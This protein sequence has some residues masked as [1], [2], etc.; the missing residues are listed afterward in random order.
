MSEKIF[1]I[2]INDA[3]DRHDG[4]PL[5]RLR[6]ELEKS[7][8]EYVM[9]AA[10]MEPD[11]RA[12]T[13]ALGFC[14][15]HLSKMMD[16]KNRLSLALVLE[17]HLA[18]ILSSVSGE[19]EKRKKKEDTAPDELAKMA[20]SCYV[21]SRVS[22]FENKYLSNIIYMWKKE[23]AFR[24]KLRSQEHFCLTHWAALIKAAK[25]ELSE[26]LYN[27]FSMQLKELEISYIKKLS[28]DVSAFCKSFDH[29]YASLPLSEDEKSS[30]NRASSFLTGDHQNG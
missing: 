4:C 6:S 19:K 10:M 13:N 2:P 11:V 16:M 7:S 26:G 3:F 15:T 12:L 23:E 18:D 21:C 24:V 29:R 1:T 5:C 17:S 27:E 28:G 9:G 14:G 20:N 30:V 8:L 25:N 22:M